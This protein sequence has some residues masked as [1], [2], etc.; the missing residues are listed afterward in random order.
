MGEVFA[1]RFLPDLLVT[2]GALLASRSLLLALPGKWF[3]LLISTGGILLLAGF[4][5]VLLQA[6]RIELGYRLLMVSGIAFA[7]GLVV[8]LAAAIGFA[9]RRVPVA[10]E[11]RQL[12]VGAAMA[13]P[14]AVLGY[15]VFVGRRQF[16]LTEVDMKIPGL[17]P[18]L[19]GLR[20][21]Q[22]SDIHLSS[23][24]SRADLQWCVAMAN[25]TRPHLAAVTGDLI[26]GIH[27]SI[28]DCLED[29]RHLRADAGVFGC[30][31]NHER[32]IDAEAYT[33]QRAAKLGMNFHRGQRSAL[34]FG[35]ARVNLAGM[36]HF[37]KRW[38]YGQNSEGLLQ[39][40]E[41]NLLLSH[42]PQAFPNI[43]KQGWDLTLAG[44]MHGGQI[45]LEL[46]NANFNVSRFRTPYVY[47]SYREGRSAIYV[48][49]GIGTIGIP[50]RL[51]APPEVALIRLRRTP[52]VL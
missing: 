4:T 13:A 46:A 52:G 14:A 5:A 37:D 24:L 49:R 10:P 6:F 51:G 39:P 30:N 18:D 20:I 44:H 45:N 42:N 19:D 40:G 48:T 28:D 22:L 38:S 31:G 2:V 34:D 11:R 21:A 36:D 50:I 16:R 35:A 12:L 17:H 43:A 3:R 23:F 32:Y 1:K 41:F 25:E 29:L 8:I 26:T 7:W 27:D 47:G 33:A 15:G 9:L